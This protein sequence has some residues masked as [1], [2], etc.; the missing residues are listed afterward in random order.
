M[1]RIMKKMMNMEVGLIWMIIDGHISLV[2]LKTYLML[3][4]MWVLVGSW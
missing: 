1:K 3:M 4:L 2:I